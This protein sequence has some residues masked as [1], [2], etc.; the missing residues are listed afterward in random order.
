MFFW[1]VA[2]TIGCCHIVGC[3]V[4]R[5]AK[6]TIKL[7]ASHTGLRVDATFLTCTYTEHGGWVFYAA[8][9]VLIKNCAIVLLRCLELTSHP[10]TIPNPSKSN[11]AQLF[12]PKHSNPTQLPLPLLATLL[13]APAYI[14]WGTKMPDMEDVH[15]WVSSCLSM[16]LSSIQFRILKLTDNPTPDNRQQDG[17]SEKST[18]LAFERPTLKICA[19]KKSI[20]I[21]CDI[22]P[23][24]LGYC[25]LHA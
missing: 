22:C 2:F 11:L 10:P 24:L 15:V 1:G 12:W 19:M 17:C 21:Y 9:Q 20:N 7:C 6:E 23:A 8:A 16:F 18:W 3:N 5:F 13:P 14:G 4:A 25:H